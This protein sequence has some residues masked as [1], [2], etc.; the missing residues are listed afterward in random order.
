MN[1][2]KKKSKPVLKN[3]AHSLEKDDNK[4]IKSKRKSLIITFFVL[5]FTATASFLIFRNISNNKL[6][7]FKTEIIPNAVKKLVNDSSVKIKIENIKEANGVYEFEISMDSENNPEEKPLKYISYITKDGE[8]LFTSGIKLNAKENEGETK[9]TSVKK[10][11]C[12]EMEKIEKPILTAFVVSQCPYGVQMQRLFYKTI[13]DLPELGNSLEIKYIGEVKNGK[14]TA[15]HGDEEAQENLKQICI[16]EEQ[17]NL[18][19]PYVSCYMKE[20]KTDECLAST[21]VNTNTLKACTDNAEKGLTYAQKDF[22]LAN[23]FNVQGS[24][25]LLI[26]NADIVS[27][28]DFGGR[29]PDAI[30]KIVCCGS[31]EEKEYCEKDLSKNEVAVSFSKTIEVESSTGSTGVSTGT[32]CE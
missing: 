32:S 9:G 12:E 3:A 22:D 13:T 31:K 27:E 15:M 16:R 26:N 19:W 5:I 1:K 2:L 30:K 25:A 6:N 20:S 8:I 18:Y 10:V 23:K 24:P 28:F 7:R 14:I 21:G 29:I 4:K 17:P 11:T